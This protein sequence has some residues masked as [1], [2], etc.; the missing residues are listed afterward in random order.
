MSNCRSGCPTQDHANWGDFLRA[1]N[2]QM[3]AGDAKH[4]AVTSS[5]KWDNRLQ[6]YRDATA[7]G[8]EPRGTSWKAIN[9]AKELS[10]KVGKAYNGDT[11]SFKD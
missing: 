2:I 3:N 4:S 1:S 9:E 8:I 6:A 7:E 10:D 11:N 5:K